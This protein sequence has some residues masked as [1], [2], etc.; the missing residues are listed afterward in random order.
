MLGGRRVKVPRSL[1][2]SVEGQKEMSF[3]SWAEWSA[4]DPSDE[5]AFEQIVLGTPARGD[6]RSLEPLTN[7]FQVH[8]I[9]KRAVKV[10][11]TALCSA[12]APID[13]H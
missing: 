6:E 13:D 4:R 12:L 8:G 2:R 7:E 1:L 5:R 11:M 3:P 9:G 10:S